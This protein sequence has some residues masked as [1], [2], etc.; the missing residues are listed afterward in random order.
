MPAHHSTV[1]VAAGLH[2]Q[3]IRQTLTVSPYCNHTRCRQGVGGIRQVQLVLKAKAGESKRVG[4]VER[5]LTSAA[6]SL[7][8]R[9]YSCRLVLIDSIL[10]SCSS[11]LQ[12]YS[13]SMKPL[14]AAQT[15]KEQQQAKLTLLLSCL[16]VG[17]V[18]TQPGQ[19]DSQRRTHTSCICKGLC[20]PSTAQW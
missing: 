12:V 4:A 5:S 1:E 11:Y 6:S 3:Q 10:L 9:P 8:W 17:K 20:G 19:V 18:R 2:V 7:V 14:S 16:L 13:T 15:A